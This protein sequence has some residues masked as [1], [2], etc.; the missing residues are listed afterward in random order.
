M[1]WIPRSST[2]FH[3]I[4]VPKPSTAYRTPADARFDSLNQNHGNLT[5][6]A[7]KGIIGIRAMAEISQIMGQ[8]MDAEKYEVLL[9]F[10]PIFMLC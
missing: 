10:L 5:N 8:S 1:P 7:I 6:L 3:F 4:L 9:I 2:P